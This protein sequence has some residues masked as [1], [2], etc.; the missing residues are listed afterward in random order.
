MPDDPRLHHIG[1]VVRSIADEVAD[2]QNAMGLSWDGR[3]IADPL[4]MVRVTFLA[5]AIAGHPL[6]E[7]VQ[8]DGR[9]S[10]VREFAESGGG[11]HHLCFE[12]EDLAARISERECAGDTLVRVPM[13]AAAFNGRRIAWM[14]TRSGALI[15]YLEAAA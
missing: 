5:T 13:R 14:R 6:I 15:E 11:I 8:P 10:P 4:Q 3:V 12:I 9:R 1:Y 7:L 2:F